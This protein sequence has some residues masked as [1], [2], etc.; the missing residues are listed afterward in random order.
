MQR[1]CSVALLLLGL[2][3]CGTPPVEHAAPAQP[4]APAAPL[5]ADAAAIAQAIA[6][7]AR[8][9][10]DRAE[11]A[12]RQPATVLLF[13]QARPGMRVIDVF[14]AGGYYSELL[15]RVAGTT[16]RVIAY[17]NPPYARFAGK[18]PAERFDDGRLP[19]VQSVTA[20]VTELSLPDNG[21]DAAL[22]VLAYHD[23]YWRPAEGGWEHTDPA[24][25]LRKL[26]AALQPG[27]V[28][29]VL[30]HAAAA[31]SEPQST[32]DRLHRIDPQRVRADFAAAGFELDAQSDA[33]AQGDDDLTRLIF[34]PSIRHRTHQFLYRF[35]KPS[36]AR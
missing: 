19:N 14:A 9:A 23:L 34:D 25:L 31:G 8:S 1:L 4:A 27:G 17:N 5:G 7:P 16:G 22:F 28:V 29:V 20:E 24:L 11:D 32:A 12:W 10:E 33:F 13:L 18:K 2:A 15:A 36:S 3:A 26:Y 6:S 30:D 35:K 21:L